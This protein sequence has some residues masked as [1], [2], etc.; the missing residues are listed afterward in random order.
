MSLRPESV[1]PVPE[2]TARVARAAFPRGN[3]YLRMRDA[4]GPLFTD[5]S[6]APLFPARGQPALSPWRLALITIMQYAEGLSDRQA[7]DAVRGRIDWKYA[8]SLELGDPGFDS[9]VLSEFRTRLLAGHAEQLLFESMLAQFRER[10]LIA[11]GGQQ[12]TDSTHIL[13]AV[14]ALNRLELVGETVRAALN[15]LAIVA[16]AWL[17]THSQPDWVE[18]YGPR[19]TEF[20]LPRRPAERETLAVTIATDGHALLDAVAGPDAPGWLRQIPAVETLRQ[21]WIQQFY[22]D[23]AGVQWRR[24]DQTPPAPRVR[25]SP[26]DPDARHGKKRET[27]WLGYK[28]HLTETCEPDAPHL[29]TQVETTSAPRPDH[30]MTTPIHEA[31][32]CKALLPGIHLVDAGYVDGGVLVASQQCYGVDL[33]GPAPPESSWQ[34]REGDGFT[35]SR[36]VVDWETEQVTCPEG[37]RSAS[38]TPAR[39]RHGNE[40]IKVKFAGGDCRSCPSRSRCTRNHEQRRTVTLRPQAEYRA[41]QAARER[42]VTADFKAAYGRRAGVEGMISQGVRRSD[43]RRCRYVGQRKTHLQHLLTAAAINFIRVAVWLEEPT[44]A[45]TRTSAFVRLMAQQATG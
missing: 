10:N 14:R 29:I 3:L 28:A 39:D 44:H 42:Q 15:A 18:R 32:R 27:A 33:L 35:A 40:V 43:L 7:A 41:L 8:L 4:L 17:R 37:K 19:V 30:T 2:E 22:E 31:L 9:S 21:T 11:A 26:Y 23:A 12:R 36:F 13:A 20:R 16:P 6:F 1:G 25:T 38:W 24:H 5:D 45:T 34:V